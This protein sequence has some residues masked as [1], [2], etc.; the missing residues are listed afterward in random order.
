VSV[1]IILGGL[2]ITMIRGFSYTKL[3]LTVLFGLLITLNAFAFI[4][5]LWFFAKAYHGQTYERLPPLGELRDIWQKY[6]QHYGGSEPEDGQ[7]RDET[8][9]LL[10][11]VEFTHNL[12]SRIIEAADCNNATNDARQDC[13]HIGVVWLFVLL[14][15]AALS[16]A[17]YAI[18]QIIV[19]GRIP[20]VHLDNFDKVRLMPNPKPSADPT[21]KP[22]PAP[23]RPKPQFPPNM[24]YKND[25]LVKDTRKK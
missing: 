18:D 11:D 19:P 17:P 6:Y 7:G 14:V 25:R 13:L 3:R 12:R 5:C 23:P 15:G 9:S 4:R 21:P 20:V 8:A 2:M 1:L 16:S 24:V 10:A 22:Q